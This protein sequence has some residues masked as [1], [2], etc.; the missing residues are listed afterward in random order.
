MLRWLI[1][2]AFIA[3]VPLQAEGTRDYEGEEFVSDPIHSD[4]PLY[5]FEWEDLWPRDY[6]DGD[7]LAGCVSRIR[8]GDWLSQPNSAD[9]S[10]DERE[11]YRFGSYGDF[12]CIANIRIAE[13]RAALADSTLDRGC[14]VKLGVEEHHGALIELWS[15]QKGLIPDSE[16]MLLAR[17]TSSGIITRVDVLQQRCPPRYWRDLAEPFDIFRTGYCAINSRAALLA[18]AESMLAFP[19]MGTLEL[20][21]GPDD[22]TPDPAEN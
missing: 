18:M 8:F 7:T 10:A 22:E 20:Q 16:Y 19:K 1:A 14:F 21:T 9:A 17:P 6:A 13:D 4:L 15:I 3:A 5:T 11:W 12:H 2:L